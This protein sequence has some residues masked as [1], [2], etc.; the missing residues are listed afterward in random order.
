MFRKILLYLTLSL[1]VYLATG[2]S[3][4]LLLEDETKM[5]A[6]NEVLSDKIS[7]LDGAGIIL[8]DTEAE[9]I[10][11]FENKDLIFENESSGVIKEKLPK[12]HSNL[13]NGTKEDTEESKNIV[14]NSSGEDNTADSTTTDSIAN[15][16]WKDITTEVIE[17]A[18]ANMSSEETVSKASVDYIEPLTPLN[19]A[20]NLTL[21]REFTQQLSN[22]NEQYITTD[23]TTESD[24][25]STEIAS[26]GPYT[27]NL[28]SD[29]ANAFQ[30][31]DMVDML[32]ITTEAVKTLGTNKPNGDVFSS[33]VDPTDRSD[34]LATTEFLIDRS[35]IDIISNQ[36]VNTDIAIVEAGGTSDQE[37]LISQST[38]SPSQ[39]VTSAPVVDSITDITISQ[40]SKTETTA[41]TPIEPTTESIQLTKTSEISSTRSS[42][43]L[44]TSEIRVPIV[45]TTVENKTE[46]ENPASN[47]NESLVSERKKDNETEINLLQT[48]T[49]RST[50]LNN[51]STTV[52]TKLP[53]HS[54]SRPKQTLLPLAW[55]T[56]LIPIYPSYM[57]NPFN[58]FY[59]ATNQTR[60]GP[61]S[62]PTTWNYTTLLSPTTVNFTNMLSKIL[63]PEVTPTARHGFFRQS[64][65]NITKFHFFPLFNLFNATNHFNKTKFATNT[66]TETATNISAVLN[67]LLQ[68]KHAKFQQRQTD[69][70][71]DDDDDGSLFV[72]RQWYSTPLVSDNLE[73]SEGVPFLTPVV[74]YRNQGQP[75]LTPVITYVE[76]GEPYRIAQPQYYRERPKLKKRPTSNYRQQP[77]YHERPYNIE[78]P[79][80]VEQHSYYHQPVKTDVRVQSGPISYE[81]SPMDLTYIEP[82]IDIDDGEVEYYYRS[83][84]LNAT[85]LQPA[86]DTPKTG[87]T[88]SLMLEVE[89]PNPIYKFMKSIYNLFMPN[90]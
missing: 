28:N 35:D 70:D 66:Q 73:R 54:S 23:V 75:L 81:S 71:N 21:T 46:P 27:I 26:E 42:T 49:F 51:R 87:A 62:L 47:S 20:F 34:E 88:T 82:I 1:L 68:H 83:K 2:S 22:D 19:D 4:E 89:V 60:S 50:E 11:Y 52:S 64:Q 84:Q 56:N 41:Y 43:I 31:S 16:L 9:A 7:Q 69:Q 13:L 44:D 48:T 5:L 40:S 45:N 17:A 67:A 14:T 76:R 61:S 90:N 58:Y 32:R 38:Q 10:K 8:N 37:I 30:S 85:A 78:R 3:E 25:K 65:S 6:N 12:A 72:R 36:D 29:E 74:R 79:Y 39:N 59:N 86:E 18:I 80:Q 15:N 57:L 24:I 53:S 33:T 77:F 63:L 55:Y